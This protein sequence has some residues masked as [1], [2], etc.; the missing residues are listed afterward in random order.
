MKDNVLK[1]LDKLKTNCLDLEKATAED[2]IVSKK[3]SF[4][5]ILSAMTFH[6]L[7][8]LPEKLK[9]LHSYLTKGGVLIFV[10]IDSDAE[11]AET[12]HCKHMKD[13]V[14]YKGGFSEKVLTNWLTENGFENAQFFRNVTVNKKGNDGIERDYVLM[15]TCAFKK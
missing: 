15:T 5:L 2:E 8:N 12:F 3:G 11:F 9:M 1:G 6:H 4:D 13:E 14:Q 7:E 10:D